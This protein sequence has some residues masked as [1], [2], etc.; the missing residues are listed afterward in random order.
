MR[1]ILRREGWIVYLAASILMWPGSM[2]GYVKVG[3]AF[4]NLLFVSYFAV[5]AVVVKA[6]DLMERSA[7]IDC[8]ARIRHRAPGVP[9]AFRWRS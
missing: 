9:P 2:L 1:A 3:G 7:T 4:N 5:L 8:C 6:Q